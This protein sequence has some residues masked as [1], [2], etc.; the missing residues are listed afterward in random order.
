[1][2]VNITVS[3]I[4]GDKNFLLALLPHI[5]RA[6]HLSLAGHSSIEGV[7]R[8]LPGFFATSMFSPTSLELEQTEE[9]SEL[10]SRWGMSRPTFPN[11]W[12]DWTASHGLLT[13]DEH[14][15]EAGPVQ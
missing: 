14:W 12:V 8:D 3:D 15:V 13:E 1:M 7:A 10:F 5:S 4:K 11:G 6:S 9:P 2:T